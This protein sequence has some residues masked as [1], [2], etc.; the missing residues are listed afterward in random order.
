MSPDDLDL[1]ERE[2]RS[3]RPWNHRELVETIIGLV[4]AL[5]L[6]GPE[7]PPAEPQDARLPV[8]EGVEP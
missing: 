7:K 4:A 6:A 8:S 5:R 3:S 1:I 2:A